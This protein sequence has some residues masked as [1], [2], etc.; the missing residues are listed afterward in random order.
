MTDAGGLGEGRMAPVLLLVDNRDSFTFN[1]AQYLAELGQEV[2][3]RRASELDLAAVLQMEPEFVVTGP[4]PGHPNQAWLSQQ[5]AL[6]L[7][8]H[9]PLLGVCLGHQALALAY[10][11]KIQRSEQPSHGRVGT[12]EHDAIG[13]FRGLPAKLSMGRYHSLVVDPDGLPQVLQVT[14]R[15]PDGAIQAVQ[16]RE[17]PRYGVQF[18]PE[19]ILSEHGHALLRNFLDVR[20]A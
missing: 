2:L 15:T 11:A 17:L 7:P 4:G 1:L 3:V 10:G 13:L 9:V 8:A 5:L 6:D 16:H 14:A 19:S 18:H 20:T 12:I